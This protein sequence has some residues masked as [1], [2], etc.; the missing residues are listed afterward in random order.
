MD[1]YTPVKEVVDE[2]T[3]TKVVVEEQTMCGFRKCC[4]HVRVFDDGSIDVEDEGQRVAF[5]KE[6]AQALLTML[7][8][9][10]NP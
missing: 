8:N 10:L 4:P 1:E 6:Q 5:D 9:K 3:I 2:K 7:K